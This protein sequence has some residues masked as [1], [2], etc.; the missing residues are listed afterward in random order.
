VPCVISHDVKALLHGPYHLHME[1]V[2]NQQVGHA[3]NSST[4]P[5][6]STG[7]CLQAQ[8]QD[9]TWNGPQHLHT[10]WRLTASRSYL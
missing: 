9:A 2:S 7:L 5:C 1:L 3:S 10:M 8:A 4:G 6:S